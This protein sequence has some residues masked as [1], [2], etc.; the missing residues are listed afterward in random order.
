MTSNEDSCCLKNGQQLEQASEQ[1]YVVLAKN[2][3]WSIYWIAFYSS[4]VSSASVYYTKRK[5]KYK[6]TTKKKWETWER[7]YL[8]NTV[9]V[10]GWNSD[11]KWYAWWSALKQWNKSTYKTCKQYYNLKQ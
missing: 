7:G 9:C 10:Q 3:Y 2:L 6:K 8:L 4:V 5:P 11:T 1:A